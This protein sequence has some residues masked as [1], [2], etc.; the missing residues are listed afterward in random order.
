MK[1][2]FEFYQAAQDNIT[3]AE[4]EIVSEII[5]GKTDFNA[6]DSVGTV[7]AF[8]EIRANIVKWYPFERN[9]SVLEIGANFGEITGFLC[10]TCNRVVALETSPQK[11]LAIAKRHENKENLEI[12]A[13]T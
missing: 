9:A 12:I 2:N 3:H 10:E 11:A 4:K 8:S 1:T 13:G 6:S 5:N 7:L